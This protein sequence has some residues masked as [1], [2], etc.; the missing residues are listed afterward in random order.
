MWAGPSRPVAAA[1]AVELTD[2][3]KMG[4]GPGEVS[5]AIQL[6]ELPEQ[7]LVEERRHP[8]TCIEET[9]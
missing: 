8:W 9:G 7:R 1:V 2:G 5:S 3:T 4:C 6:Y